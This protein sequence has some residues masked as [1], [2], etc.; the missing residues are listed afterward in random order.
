MTRTSVDLASRHVR[1]TAQ[2]RRNCDTK[3]L[4]PSNGR[5]L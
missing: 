4:H 3:I 5:P 2:S 1:S